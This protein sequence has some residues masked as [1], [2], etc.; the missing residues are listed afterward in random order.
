VAARAKVVEKRATVAGDG[1]RVMNCEGR[2]S[3]AAGRVRASIVNGFV[4]A[5]VGAGGRGKGLWRLDRTLLRSEVTV[6][7]GQSTEAILQ[8]LVI[9]T[10]VIGRI[11][12]MATTS[13]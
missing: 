11:L 5:I 9:P 6:D 1:R 13:R 12:T 10:D 3:V 8:A 2:S 7:D 4:L